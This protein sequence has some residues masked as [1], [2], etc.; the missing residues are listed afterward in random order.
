MCAQ[1]CGLSRQHRAPLFID[2]GGLLLGSQVVERAQIGSN[3]GVAPR[4][5]E[6]EELRE[7]FVF[8]F[9][10]I[11]QLFCPQS[12]HPH[13]QMPARIDSSSAAGSSGSSAASKTDNLHKVGGPPSIPGK[14]R[15]TA[16]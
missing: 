3:G 15:P 11:S 5:K 7:M 8:I 12:L 9:L 1:A 10:F 2:L 16:L 14:V 13:H 6:K 4:Q